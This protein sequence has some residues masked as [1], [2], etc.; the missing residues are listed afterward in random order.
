[1]QLYLYYLRL[2]PFLIYIY[3]SLLVHPMLSVFV[4]HIFLID[5]GLN[6]VQNSLVEQAI[7]I[8]PF[9]YN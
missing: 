9:I 7:L 8:F 1:M 4:Y 3:S 2:A 6:K 5:C